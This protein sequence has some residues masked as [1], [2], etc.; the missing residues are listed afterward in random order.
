MKS[1]RSLVQLMENLLVH[2]HKL[3][4]LTTVLKSDYRVNNNIDILVIASINEKRISIN[5]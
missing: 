4:C 1:F 2:L 5:E 3:Y